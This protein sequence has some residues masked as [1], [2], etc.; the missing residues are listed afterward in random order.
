MQYPQKQEVNKYLN[1]HCL[2]LA[3]IKKSFLESRG[4]KFGML[5]KKKSHTLLVAGPLVPGVSKG[6]T[7]SA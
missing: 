4:E 7:D 2:G 6:V 1:P 5:I 3:G